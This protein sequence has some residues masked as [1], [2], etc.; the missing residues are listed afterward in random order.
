MQPACCNGIMSLF[1]LVTDYD[2]WGQGLF[3]FFFFSPLALCPFVNV[4]CGMKEEE[5]EE[6]HPCLLSPESIILLK[7]NIKII[8]NVFFSKV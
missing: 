3:F 4:C 5:K 1:A 2:S 6:K 8:W 7:K